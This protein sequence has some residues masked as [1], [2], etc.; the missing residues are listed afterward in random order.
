MGKKDFIET[1]ILKTI[2]ALPS[3]ISDNLDH[4]TDQSVLS[5]H[6]YELMVIIIRKFIL[7]RVN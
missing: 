2:R 5:D 4:M 3:G 1:L 6:R 7:I